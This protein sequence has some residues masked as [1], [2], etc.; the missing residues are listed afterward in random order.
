MRIDDRAAAEVMLFAAKAGLRVAQL[1]AQEKATPNTAQTSNA[2][3]H[4]AR[5]LK[6]ARH[7]AASW[8]R[9]ADLVEAEHV[10][11]DTTE[12]DTAAMTSTPERTVAWTNADGSP[13]TGVLCN[14][15]TCRSFYGGVSKWMPL[16]S[17]DLPEGGICV[18]C[19]T[20][21]LA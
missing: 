19:G 6:G 16:R 11:Q 14:T 10:A 20:D 13:D 7:L 12:R 1:E 18:R 4:L 9:I 5:K 3:L 2:R 8:M 21:V 15:G 17:E